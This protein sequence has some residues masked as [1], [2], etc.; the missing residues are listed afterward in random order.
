M[1]WVPLS[2][3]RWMRRPSEERNGATPAARG[4]FAASRWMALGNGQEAVGVGAGGAV[5]GQH[6]LVAGFLADLFQAAA[7]QPQQGLRPEEGAEETFGERPGIITAGDVGQLVNQDGPQGNRVELGF[8]G[9]GKKDRRAPKA[10]QKRAEN[11]RMR[12][13][14]R[15]VGC[16]ACESLKGR[17]GR[18]RRKRC[19]AGGSSAIGKCRARAGGRWFPGARGT[20]PATSCFPSRFGRGK[21]F[22]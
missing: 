12:Q 13:Q 8:V 15:W 10:G 11:R 22:G 18:G 1:A 3:M 6:G 7:E 4:A 14:T 16:E 19:G 5:A 21:R 20:H 2:R 17:P 9:G